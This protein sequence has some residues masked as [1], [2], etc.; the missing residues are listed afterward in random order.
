MWADYVIKELCRQFVS[1]KSCAGS[2]YHQRVVQT[3]YIIN[4]L[5]WQF[6]SLKSC[7]GSLHHFK[8]CAGRLYH[9]MENTLKERHSLHCMKW[10]ECCCFDFCCFGGSV[11]FIFSSYKL[12][13]IWFKY[14]SIHVCKCDGQFNPLRKENKPRKITN[15]NTN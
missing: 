12:L 15:N 9:E 8:S 7:V 3:V 1:L 2:L 5:C 10:M 6:I 4:E 11:L 13:V 14:G